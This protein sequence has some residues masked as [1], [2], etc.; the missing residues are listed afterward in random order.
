MSSLDTGPSL[1]SRALHSMPTM[2]DWEEEC[3]P[4]TGYNPKLGQPSVESCGKKMVVG[5]TSINDKWGMY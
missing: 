1:R 3:E 5:E 4:P 2:S